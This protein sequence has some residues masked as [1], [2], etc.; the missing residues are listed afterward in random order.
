MLFAYDMGTSTVAHSF[1]YDAG[2]NMLSNSGVGA[3]VYPL[4]SEARPHTPLTVD[5]SPLAYDANGNMTLGLAS[6]A[7]TYNYA[8]EPTQVVFA[9]QTTTYTYGPGAIRQTKVVDGVTTFYTSIAEIRN[10]GTASETIILQ[11]HA[12]FRITNAGGA[13]EAISYLHRDHL[14]SVRLITNAAGISEQSNSY[15]P[16]GDPDTQTLLAT[17]IPEE[18]FDASTGLLFHTLDSII[19]GWKPIVF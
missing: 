19:S 11:P 8:N 10:F 7:I 13:S 3:Y 5:G 15:T 14:A 4:S 16:F 12:D 17:A 1:T 9:G 18:R 6:K 2:G